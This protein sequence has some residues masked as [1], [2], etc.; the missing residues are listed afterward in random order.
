MTSNCVSCSVSYY[1]DKSAD[2][3][4][5]L[6]K[7]SGD[8]YQLVILDIMMPGMD[9]LNVLSEIRRSSNVPVMMLTARGDDADRIA[10]RICFE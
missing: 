4:D 9:G 10:G 3:R 8:E 1:A 6:R 7:L 2:R 5:G